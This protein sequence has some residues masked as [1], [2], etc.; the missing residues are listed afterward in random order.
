MMNVNTG[1]TTYRNA[2][3]KACLDRG[4]PVSSI[5]KTT[6]PMRGKSNEEKEQLAKEALEKL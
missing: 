4:M 3:L 1:D 2:L 6:A 5:E